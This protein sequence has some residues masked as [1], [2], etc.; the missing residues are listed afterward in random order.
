[1]SGVWDPDS[2]A[3]QISLRTSDQP[4]VSK[5]PSGA[6]KP[7]TWTGEGST[8]PS[9]GFYL[10]ACGSVYSGTREDPSRNRPRIGQRFSSARAI[11]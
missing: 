4:G 10:S 8:I 2:G 11:A 3:T 1:M 7:A 5:Y 6:V 9:D